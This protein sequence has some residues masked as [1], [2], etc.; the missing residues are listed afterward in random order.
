M[1][2]PN[3]FSPVVVSPGPVVAPVLGGKLKFNTSDRFIRELRRR[4]DAYFEKTGRRRRDCPSMYFK[5]AT[6]MAW[7]FGAYFLLLFAVHT[8]WLIV[9][10]AV[11][12]GLALAAIGFNIQHDG[13]H[14]GYS[15]SKIVN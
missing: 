1:I 4:V 7:F 15:N 12:L 3:T 9:P 14:Q 11:V 5:T 6:I 8:W 10:L 2:P 13:A